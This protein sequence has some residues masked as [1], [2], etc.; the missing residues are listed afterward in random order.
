MI[1]PMDIRRAP[2]VETGKLA[3]LFILAYVAGVLSAHDT[4]NTAW[5]LYLICFAGAVALLGVLMREV[6]NP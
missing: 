2:I 3:A 5:W 6:W 1:S 4:G